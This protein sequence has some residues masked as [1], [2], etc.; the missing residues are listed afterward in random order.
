RLDKKSV[1]LYAVTTG[2]LD[3]VRYMTVEK[4]LQLNVTIP[5]S[6]PE[7]TADKNRLIQILFNLIHNAVKFTDEGII[8]ISATHN[9]DMA[10]IRVTDTGIG[11][12]EKFQQVIF[13]PYRQD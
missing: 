4:N 10:M 11:M 12:D 7:I 6:F 8:T 1:K 9:A 2:V 3:M 13:Q 5:S